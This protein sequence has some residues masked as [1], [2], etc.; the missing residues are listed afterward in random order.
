MTRKGR[1]G[2]DS[3]YQKQPQWTCKR[4][5]SIPPLFYG[6]KENYIVGQLCSLESEVLCGFHWQT[7]PPSSSIIF[8][9]GFLHE[10]WADHGLRCPLSLS[11]LG[12][13]CPPQSQCQALPC[14]GAATDCGL[15]GASRRCLGDNSNKPNWE[16]EGAQFLGQPLFLVAVCFRYQFWSTSFGCP[17]SSLRTDK[18]TG[19][20]Q[21]NSQGCLQAT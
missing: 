13:P 2:G 17:K 12:L 14:P 9:E 3:S 21:P 20:L 8:P 10:S 7:N 6:N 4:E 11:K 18:V 15:A 19:Q 1:L 5:R 16:T